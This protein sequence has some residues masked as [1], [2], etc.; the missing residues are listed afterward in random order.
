MRRVC[1]LFAIALFCSGCAA[2]DR[3]AAPPLP[4]QPPCESTAFCKDGETMVRPEAPADP[5]ADGPAVGGASGD[6]ACQIF[7]VIEFFIHMP[8][9]VRRTARLDRL[10][11]YIALPHDAWMKGRARIDVAQTKRFSG[12]L[13]V[14]FERNGAPV[15]ITHPNLTMN[16]IRIPAGTRGRLRARMEQVNQQL[17][18]DRHGFLFDPPAALGPGQPYAEETVKGV[19]QWKETNHSP[20]YI[21]KVEQSIKIRWF[22]T[23]PLADYTGPNRDAGDVNN[24]VRVTTQP[25]GQ[26]PP[27][28]SADD[29]PMAISPLEVFWPVAQFGTC[30][31]EQCREKVI[32]FARAVLIDA[33]P[34]NHTRGKDWS[35]DIKESEKARARNGEAYDPTFTNDPRGTGAGESRTF[36]GQLAGGGN[37]VVQFDAP[38]LTRWLYNQFLVAPGPVTFKQQFIAFFVCEPTGGS[39]SLDRRYLRNARLVKVMKYTV[40]WRFP[41]LSPQGRPQI[42][43]ISASVDEVIDTADV[44]HAALR[45]KRILEQLMQVNGLLDAYRDPAAARLG[46]MAP[47]EH[48]RLGGSVENQRLR[49]L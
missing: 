25:R 34:P 7:G 18:A 6:G 4:P 23:G 44:Q 11:D 19:I 27:E 35:L 26:T 10:G 20:A 33:P 2:R 17:A 39:G 8:G 21:C 9:D 30:C 36:E 28:P 12:I 13:T 38:G 31:N 3:E 29:W 22:R 37:A 48:R 5:F 46:I 47:D 43:A 32:Q 24:P 15:P 49:T 45:C 1:W 14:T 40:T 42:P 16:E 41:G